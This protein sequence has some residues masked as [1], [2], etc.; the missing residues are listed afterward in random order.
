MIKLDKVDK[1]FYK[2]KSNEIHV[3]DNTSLEFP[4]KG[5]VAL[6]GKSGSGKTTL[7]NVIGGLDSFDSGSIKVEDHLITDYNPKVIDSFRSKKIGYIFQNYYL[8][9]DKTVYENLEISLRL[10]GLTDKEETERRIDYSLSLV[11]LLKFKKRFPNTLSGGQQQRVAIARALVKG[12]S[13]IIADEPTGNLDSDNTFEVMDLLKSISRTCLV[14]LVTH[15]EDIANFFAD[16]IIRLK[17]GRIIEDYINESITDLYVADNKKIYL[18]DLKFNKVT[19]ADNVTINYNGDRKSDFVINIIEKD[20]RLYIDSYNTS[21]PVSLIDDKSEVKVVDAH[22][23]DKKKGEHKSIAV[24]TNI[25]TEIKGDEKSVIDIKSTFIK[26]WKNSRRTSFKTKGASYILLFLSACIIMVCAYFVNMFLV[27]NEKGYNENR[28][29]IVFNVQDISEL[30]E[31]EGSN[32]IDKVLCLGNIRIKPLI[33][34]IFNDNYD[35]SEYMGL[36]NTYPLSVLDKPKLVHGILPS[37]D[38]EAV[39]DV[40]YQ[41]VVQGYFFRYGN[42]NK[43]YD[44]LIGEKLI[45][46]ENIYTITGIVDSGYNGAFIS[47][48]DFNKEMQNYTSQYNV[49]VLSSN[50]ALTKK[51]AEDNHY[52]FMDPY[53]RALEDFAQARKQVLY[54]ISIFMVIALGFLVFINYHNV[55]SSFMNK[56]KIIGTYRCIGVKK[57][58]LLKE[59]IIE[60][61]IALSSSALIGLILSG[62]VMDKISPL[63]E[64]YNIVMHG[65]FLIYIIVFILIYGINIGL[66]ALKV[67]SLLRLTPA[68][69]MAKY[70]I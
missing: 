15:E 20:G 58:E 65:S 12:P 46:N 19:K 40:R 68:Q 64:F 23:Q 52:A 41:E 44:F 67:F 8:L 1:Y 22:Y 16:R 50:K 18:K 45:I 31:L 17:D 39:I 61:I 34:G 9:N 43:D 3:I 69:I 10:A 14:V 59:F 30:K 6:L 56:I 49:S 36:Y 55:K 29:L 66:T 37:A 57:T 54:I 21:M 5:L 47:E 51:W 38:N 7:L 32:G 25:L 27:F 2:R 62:I 60:N 4:E 42:I 26:A 28:N 11:G 13:I 35:I 48:S 24:D 33:N 53:G 63:F 70:D